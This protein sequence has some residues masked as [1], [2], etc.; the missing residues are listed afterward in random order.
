[1]FNKILIA[2]R[3]E[4]AVR[5]CRSAHTLGIST[6]AIY[7]E[8]DKASLH[9]SMATEAVSLGEGKLSDT[10]L[11][12]DKIIAIAQ[13][14]ACDA[15]HP[16]YGF[17]SENPIFVKACEDA[18]IVFI[19]PSSEAIKL[20]GNKIAARKF[21]KEA[22]VP[23]TEGFTG[24]TEEI[25]EKAS[26]LP[27]PLLI[28]AAAGGGGKGMRIVQ[29]ADQLKQAIASTSREAKSYF[30]DES[31]YVEQFL[32]EPR[33]IEVQILGDQQGNLVHLFERE[34][35]LQRRYQKIIEESPSPS[36]DARTRKAICESAV[37][38]A[39][40]IPYTNAG[41]I[42]FLLDK[43]QQ[44]Y[45]LEMNTRIQVEHPITEMTTGV[46]LVAE[47]IRIAAGQ[48]LRFVQED[49]QQKGHA[50]ECRIYAE[51]PENN[52]LPSPGDITY[53]SPPQASQYR[54]DTFLE[55]SARI[56]SSYDP[57]IAKL[58]VYGINREQ[59]RKG[60]MS[61]LKNCAIH[62]I[63]T[64]TH[65]LLHLLQSEDFQQNQISTK[66]CDQET[67]RLLKEMHVQKKDF[68]LLPIIAAGL[69]FELRA[70]HEAAHKPQSIWREIGY[71]RHLPAIHVSVKDEEMDVEVWKIRGGE[72]ELLSG[73]EPIPFKILH[74]DEGKIVYQLNEVEH[75]AYV[76]LKE[77]Q[78][79]QIS[80]EGMLF[81]MR[82]FD[83]LA[84]SELIIEEGAKEGAADKLSSPMPGK[85]I[86]LNV[87]NGDKVK[88]GDVL[89]IVEAMK[90]ENSII[91]PHDA[92]VDEVYVEPDAM[93]DRNMPLLKLS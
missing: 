61:A 10:Y 27:F 21:A 33:H 56:Q 38:L 24:S 32:D 19:G 18:G 30:G 66:Y 80:L 3:G 25:L 15:I 91:A 28:K 1:M 2:N 12:I 62:G 63:D 67:P 88:K 44:F 84:D 9:A 37:Q 5:I 41:T 14:Y 39:K 54:L 59:A 83:K 85:V 58:I 71:W 46:D 87:K 68:P 78:S 65:Y 70:Q 52:F 90:M 11:N 73:N 89:L 72:Y 60:S 47:Q 31:I 40:A 48:P 51:S 13:Q 29:E 16:G 22:G 4:I 77:D 45:F 74:K 8:D 81:H 23:I 6:I 43:K 86:Q 69:A 26:G 20:M 79:L 93:V 92:T 64:N 53:F 49:I 17:L 35:S 42:E 7:A 82:R 57:M 75:T 55:G 76:S 34:C 36:L 50:I